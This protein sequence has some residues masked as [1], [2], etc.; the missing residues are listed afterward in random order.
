MLMEYKEGVLIEKNIAEK[1]TIGQCYDGVVNRWREWRM[2]NRVIY[3][4]KV[5]EDTY[6]VELGKKVM[7]DSSFEVQESSANVCYEAIK[8][9]YD[10]CVTRA[11]KLENKVYILLAA[12]TFIF[13]LLTAQIDKIGKMKFPSN[14][15]ELC[16]VLLYVITLIIAIASN[17]LMIILSINLL[18]SAKFERIDEAILLTQGLLDESDITAVKFIGR[19]YV[20]NTER[21]NAILE[22]KY[23]RFNKCAVLFC[24]CTIAGI[25][26]ALLSNIICV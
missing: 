7:A 22:E 19:L 3:N 5:N 10:Y 14:R 9:E 17:V 21:N 23:S 6:Q 4:V 13:A 2:E 15:T 1:C 25:V 8:S 18:K 12:C 20:Q 16:I 24:V 26:L 11:E